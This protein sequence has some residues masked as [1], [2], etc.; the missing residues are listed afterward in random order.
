MAST[1]RHDP[2]RLL[3]FMQ[4][5]T[6][7]RTGG[8]LAAISLIVAA[9]LA[10]VRV[11]LGQVAPDAAVTDLVGLALFLAVVLGGAAG[12]RW[13][14]RRLTYRVGVRLFL[15]Y[16]LIGLVPFPLLA[17]LGAIFGYVAI[18]QYGSTRVGEE[19]DKIVERLS[20]TAAS[21]L[22]ELEARGAEAALALLHEP[23]LE[24]VG[25]DLRTLALVAAGEKAWRAAGS[26]E[27]AVPAWAGEG[28][29]RGLVLV[30]ER[31]FAAVVARRGTL[32][33][34][35]LV[36][37]DRATAE[38]LARDRWFDL[39]YMVREE[40]E[41]ATGEEKRGVTVQV[42]GE[43][44]GDAVVQIDGRSVDEE[45]VEAGWIG[46]QRP[47]GNW[48]DRRQ[49]VWVH[50]PET[51]RSWVDGNEVTG[52]RLVTLVK[53]SVGGAVR[54]LFGT[55]REVG[56][57]VVTALLVSGAV[58]GAIYL[59]AVAFA[60]VMIV[61]IT[62]ATTR[63]SRGA[64]EVAGGNLEWR[65]PVR[66]RDQLGDL[67][68]SFTSMSESVKHMLLEV[69]EKE[70]LA[71]EMELAREIQESLLP[72]REFS[73]GGLAV[74]AHF[75]P[76]TEVGGDYFD[77]FPLSGSRLILTIGDVA[78]H[79]LSTGL[80]MAMV[81][82]AVA[83]LVHDGHRGV[84]LLENLNELLLRQSAKNRMVTLALLEVDEAVGCVTITNTGHPPAFVL[85]PGDEIEEVL[86]SAL[87]LGHRWPGS[88]ASRTV[89]FP[90]GS[91]LVIYS[92]GLVE[93]ENAA[94]EAYGYEALGRLL[95]RH[96]DLPAPAMLLAIL[97]ELDRH[98]GGG[99]LADDLTV[100]VVE[101]ALP[102]S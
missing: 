89:P 91:K 58:F 60:V 28:E 4:P 39:R 31:P 14:W 33:S 18:G 48:W 93:A 21:A 36:P 42:G 54:D 80:L 71:R 97:A 40:S 49:I 25:R 67:A 84:G 101:S 45:Q 66:K 85:R 73:H 72:R 3:P 5:P 19:S 50:F 27:L 102:T 16:L 12:L 95:A 62:R 17:L 7:P 86:L 1:S 98:T 22:H 6:P 65:I 46:K 99:A 78:G 64:R 30:G 32:L 77:V 63:L 34:A 68:L 87:P 76:A 15:S 82:S 92:D 75:R 23:A 94:G 43:R 59:V 11:L 51:P 69:A 79:G 53:V 90:A 47:A 29:F 13:L 35:V 56:R 9:A 41:S 70:R 83:T 61:A 74:H 96:A 81:K 57:G 55:Q 100:L 20:A 8:R 38:A 2:A 26:E 52:R 44:R 10:V 24:G 88:P 37:L